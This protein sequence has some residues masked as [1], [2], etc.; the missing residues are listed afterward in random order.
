MDPS[1]AAKHTIPEL[2][3]ARANG[4]VIDPA[5]GRGN[6]GYEVARRQAEIGVHPDTISS[7]LTAGGRKQ[8][9][10][11]LDSMSKFMS[12]GYSLTDVVRMAT[13]NAAKGIGMG[14]SLGALAV[15]R[16]ADISI[17]DVV[18]G[19]WKFDD[20]VKH[21]FTGTHALIPVQT[22]RAGELFSPDWGPYPWGWLP[23]EA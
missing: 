15:G 21:V 13:I 10:G 2:Q 19:K 16:D 1:D 3:E 20:T 8:G 6:F 9:T 22:I 11:L 18:E 17:F 7:D 5:L 12:V 23:E 14:D 4:V